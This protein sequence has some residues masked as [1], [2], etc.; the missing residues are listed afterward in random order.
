MK[1]KDVMTKDPACC[2]ASDTVEQCA[3]MMKTHGRDNTKTGEMVR[4]I[5]EP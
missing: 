3:E 1:S 5:S 2:V 4:E